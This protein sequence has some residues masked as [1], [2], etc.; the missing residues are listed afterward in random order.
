MFAISIII[1]GASSIKHHYLFYPDLG[2]YD[3]TAKTNSEDSTS[4]NSSWSSFDLG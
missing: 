2:F 4:D 3:K 1:T